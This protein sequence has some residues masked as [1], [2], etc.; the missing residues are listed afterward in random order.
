MRHHHLGY[1]AACGVAFV[2]GSTPAFASDGVKTAGEILR[3]A[4]PVAAGGLSLYKKDY[5]GVLQF[6]VSEVIAEGTSLVLQ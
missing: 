4:L 5:D 1:V 3:I 6:T 2:A